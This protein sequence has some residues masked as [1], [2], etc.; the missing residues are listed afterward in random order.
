MLGKMSEENILIDANI[1]LEVLLEQK[2][3]RDC[4]NF[5]KEVQEGKTKAFISNFTIDT[6]ILSMTRCNLEN[7][8]I[9]IFLKSL[10]NFKTLKIYPVGFRDRFLALDFMERY[11]LDYEDAI[12]LQ[13]AI[14]S[15]CSKI[16][17][18]DKH[19]DKIKEVKRIEP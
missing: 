10:T 17:T 3:S 5:L 1:F 11:S 14:S 9:K 4:I 19:F 13:S 7:K 12:T 15:Q 6:I 16:L 18:F 2:K 8:K